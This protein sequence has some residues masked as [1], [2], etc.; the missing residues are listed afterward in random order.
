MP[1]LSTKPANGSLLMLLLCLYY[2]KLTE[3]YRHLSNGV[4]IIFFIR[5]Y[6]VPFKYW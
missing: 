6:V 1:L 4:S 2:K 3:N 5:I